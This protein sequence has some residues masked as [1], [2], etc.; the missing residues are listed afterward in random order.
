MSFHSQFRSNTHTPCIFHQW[1]WM[2]QLFGAW[3]FLLPEVRKPSLPREI[4]FCNGLEKGIIINTYLCHHLRW[5][6]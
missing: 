3:S 6:S 5:C 4:L 1:L 2:Y